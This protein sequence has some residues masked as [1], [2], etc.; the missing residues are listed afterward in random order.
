METESPLPCSQKPA[1]CFCPSQL[2]VVHSFPSYSPTKHFNI[3]HLSTPTNFT[4]VSIPK[5]LHT[6]QPLPCIRLN[7]SPHTC[8]MPA[9]LIPLRGPFLAPRHI[10]IYSAA[11]FRL[12]CR[13]PCRLIYD[14]TP[15]TGNQLLV[16][17]AA[18]DSTVCGTN[19]ETAAATTR[20]FHRLLTV[21]QSTDTDRGIYR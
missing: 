9:H 13:R 11:F 6:A 5:S 20:Y 8:H 18:V 1:T 16:G 2:Y 4:P 12:K 7:H 15:D 19:L 17:A 14:L 3:I 21:Q 10:I